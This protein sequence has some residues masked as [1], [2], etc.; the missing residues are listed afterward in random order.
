MSTLRISEEHPLCHDQQQDLPCHSPLVTITL[1]DHGSSRREWMLSRHWVSRAALEN[2]GSPISSSVSHTCFGCPF[3][4][5]TESSAAQLLA[6]LWP[7]GKWSWQKEKL[8]QPQLLCLL[9]SIVREGG[10]TSASQVLQRKSGNIPFS[11]G[12]FAAAGV[13]LECV[14]HWWHSTAKHR[15]DGA[16]SYLVLLAALAQQSWFGLKWERSVPLGWGVNGGLA[17]QELKASFLDLLLLF[18]KYSLFTGRWWKIF[19]WVCDCLVPS[20][21]LIWGRGGKPS[22]KNQKP[23]QPTNLVYSLESWS[24]TSNWLEQLLPFPRRLL[25]CM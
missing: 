22:P 14:L 8:N 23:G 16:V 9:N 10:D 11:L 7:Q 12:L 17:I 18:A 21:P 5:G 15:S 19:L 1:W 24:N 13:T 3:S 6:N 25:K 20:K 4:Q 2:T